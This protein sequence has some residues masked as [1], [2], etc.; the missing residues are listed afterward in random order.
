MRASTTLGRF[1][2]IGLV[3][4]AALVE[5][6]RP[7][8]SSPEPVRPPHTLALIAKTVAITII[9]CSILMVIGGLLFMRSGVYPIAAD[10]PHFAIVRWL[11]QNG[12]T[13][14]VRF[15]STGIRAPN[16]RDRSLFT[17]GFLLYRKNCQP[18]H[19]APGVASDAIGMG[20]NPKPPQL[21]TVGIDWNESELYWIVSRGLKMSG[22]PAF[23]PRLSDGDRWAIIS[24]LRRLS[25]MSPAEYRGACSAVDEGRQPVSWGI[26]DDTGFARIRAANVSAG[27]KRL[28]DYGCI[29]CHTIPGTGW[30]LVG[31][32]LADFAERQYIAGFL[33]S[34]P[35]NTINWIMDP[36]GYK[37]GAAMPN[38]NVQAQDAVDIAGYLYSLGDQKR[39][40]VLQQ[41]TSHT[42]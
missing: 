5:L 40:R 32:P 20:I 11:L 26:D 28:R 41:T 39:I 25:R 22:M 2:A 3:L 17:H 38:L 9:T 18:C 21:A 19:G 4:Y 36:Q 7:K 15:H 14:S 29:T 24:F 1:G 12:R 35:T 13:Y 37:P 6:V 8:N 33:V 16:L 30:G 42:H 34:V 31:P 27:R 10:R 23:A